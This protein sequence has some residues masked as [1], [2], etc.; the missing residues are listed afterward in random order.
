MRKVCKDD[1]VCTGIQ[2]GSRFPRAVE[3]SH[4]NKL[5]IADT[6]QFSNFWMFVEF[7]YPQ[8]GLKVIS[9][10]YTSEGVKSFVGKAE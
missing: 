5:L 1:C 7:Y 8:N 9:V 2:H 3:D 4:S 10:A 6:L